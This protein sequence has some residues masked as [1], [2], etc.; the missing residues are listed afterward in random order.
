MK[1]LLLSALF[2]S[3]LL[4]SAIEPGVVTEITYPC[5]YDNSKQPAL[6]MTTDAPG[7]RPL[8]VVLHTWSSNYAQNKHYGKRLKKHGVYFIAPDFRGPNTTG[9]KLAMGSDAAISDIVDAVEYM[10]KN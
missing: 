8:F 9:N 4:L 3:A 6:V 7:A 10:K 2:T 1:K 5:K